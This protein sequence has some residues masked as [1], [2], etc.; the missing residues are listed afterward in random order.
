MGATRYVVCD[1]FQR[2]EAPGHQCH[3]SAA[4]AQL[5]GQRLAYA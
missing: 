4:L 3:S 2:V 5:I 1:P